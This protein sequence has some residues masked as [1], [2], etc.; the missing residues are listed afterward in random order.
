[1]SPQLLIFTGRCTQA[2][3]TIGFVLLFGYGLYVS[4][5]Q[6]LTQGITLISIGLIIAWSV[7]LIT[8][9][10]YLAAESYRHRTIRD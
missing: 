3:G 5:L 8:G 1:M 9:G 4:I 10:C 7:A 6:D 2:F